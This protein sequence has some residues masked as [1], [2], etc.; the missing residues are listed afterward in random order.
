LKVIVTDGDERAALAATRSLGRMGD[1]HVVAEGRRSLAGVSRHARRAHRAPSPLREARAFAARLGDL[2]RAIGADAVLPISDAA[3]QALLPARLALAPTALVAPDAGAYARLSDKGAVA[4]LARAHG[5]AIPT[6]A[7]ASSEG[8]ALERARELGWPVMLKPVHSVARDAGGRLRKQG[9]ERA[10]DPESLRAAWRRAVAP[11]RALVQ[12]I[13]PGRGEGL[14]LLRARGQTIASF[15]HR[16]LREKPP[17]GGLSVLR[18]SIAVAPDRLRRVEAVLDAAGFEGAAMAE[19]RCDGENAWLMEFN[20]RLWGSLQLALDAG[21][22]FPRLLVELALGGHPARVERF[23]LGVRSRW[24]LGDLD[25]AI[26]LARGHRDADG[27]TGAGAALRVLLTPSGP[28]TR[29]EVLRPGD[30]RP[31]L[32]ELA[33]WAGALLARR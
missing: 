14:F 1:V 31:F 19:F 9:A 10:A 2:A 12:R 20:A 17:E 5:I 24:E 4:E 33:G 6:G 26:A 27:R 15:A 16:R 32:R 23:R 11:G 29:W 22:D 7:E 25:H 18:E 3:C 21:V 13:V 8:E 28:G 30:P